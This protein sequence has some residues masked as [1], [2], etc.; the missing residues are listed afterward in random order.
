MARA[1]KTA[2]VD[3]NAPTVLTADRIQRLTCPDGAAKVFLRDVE[4]PGFKVRCTSTGAKSFVFECKIDGKSRSFTIGSVEAWQISDARAEARRLAVLVDQGQ[5][6]AELDRA[7]AEAKAQAKAEKERSANYT[8]QALMADYADHLERLGKS[9]HDKVRGMFK[10]HLTTNNP[11]LANTPAALVTAEQVTDLMRDLVEE[12]KDRTAGKLRSY[13]G[14]A[15]ELARKSPTD[16]KTPTRFKAYG[17]THNPAR[18]T[19][20]IEL[21]TDKNPL[22]PDQLRQYW[23]AIE[24]LDGLRGAVLR[25]HM[26]T[27]G[28]RIEQLR[29]LKRSDISNGSITIFDRKG[30]PKKSGGLTI[31]AHGVP[32]LPQAQDDLNLLLALNPG[33]YPMSV[34]GG[35]TPMAARTFSQWAK[36]A[37][38]GLDWDAGPFQAKRLRS[39]VETALASLRV[40]QEIRGHLLSHGIAGVQA[41]SYDGH[42]YA[43]QKLEA[44]ETLHRYLTETSAS[45]MHVEFGKAA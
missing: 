18:D 17:V 37:V 43:P 39:G 12:K 14:A 13:A 3:T 44:L 41:A 31:R 35:E 30:L 8:F 33:D 25:L 28:Q 5:D 26:L 24:Q 9:S 29:K 11:K 4:M 23:R 40:S 27:G 42:T 19:T 1:A 22:E 45:V 2:P 15:F 16:A 34:D 32:L 7:K 38:T 10:L 36:D 21:K 20:S 6:P